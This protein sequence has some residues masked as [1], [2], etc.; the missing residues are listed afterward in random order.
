MEGAIKALAPADAPGRS[1]GPLEALARALADLPAAE[2]C[3]GVPWGHAQG[4]GPAMCRTG[5]RVLWVHY[6]PERCAGGRQD[7]GPA[8]CRAPYT[9]ASG[10]I[11][12]AGMPAA[13]QCFETSRP[14]GVRA[15][16]PG[17]L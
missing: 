5:A 12:V 10:C 14:L 3:A 17:A 13:E 6:A 11:T 15:A 2:Q 8:W 9:G 4:A 1:I 7:I 16:H